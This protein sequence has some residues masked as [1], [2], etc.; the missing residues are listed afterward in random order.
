MYE[1]YTQYTTQNKFM[2][3]Y[4]P[5]VLGISAHKTEV[6]IYSHR[7]HTYADY[8]LRNSRGHMPSHTLRCKH[9]E[10][11]HIFLSFSCLP[12]SPAVLLLS[13]LA[14]HHLFSHLLIL[15]SL[16]LAHFPSPSFF[17]SP[18]QMTL[19]PL[20]IPINEKLYK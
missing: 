13:H 6:N 3:N 14:A 19:P 15:S 8:M 2:S 1:I 9:T 12:L 17:F 10:N 4:T 20:C 18:A 11:T 5:T 7:L 16:G